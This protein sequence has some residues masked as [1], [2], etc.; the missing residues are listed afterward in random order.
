MINDKKN[1]IQHQKPLPERPACVG[2]EEDILKLWERKKIFEKSLA[3]TKKGKKFVFYEGPPTA[4]GMPGIHHIE[5]RAFKDAVLRYK[6]MRGFHVP[7]RAGWDTHGLPV[8]I[9]VEKKLGFK[10]K[11]EIENYGIAKFNAEA[12]KSVWEYKE[13]WE[14]LTKRMGFWIDMK[15]PYITYDTSYIESLWWI[16]KE[17]WKKGLLYEDFK[18]VPWCPRCQTGLSSHEVGLGYQEDTDTAVYAKFKLKPNQKIGDF[19]TD[20]KT[21]ILAWT[22][23]PWTLP[24]NVGLAVGGSMTYIIDE[25]LGGKVWRGEDEGD[26]F[27]F[28]SGKYIVSLEALQ[29]H[30]LKYKYNSI[31]PF[32]EIFIPDETGEF[33]EVKKING[34]DL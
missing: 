5:A 4:N 32:A 15:H 6:T 33:S 30:L 10:T 22:T 21:Y 3:R 12:K 31:N 34:V 14:R 23:T 24:G 18:V 28:K 8:E 20:D 26:A 19:T 17:F 1:S 2:R 9:Q 25:T 7:R 11:Q 27:E 16:I 13:E 29:N